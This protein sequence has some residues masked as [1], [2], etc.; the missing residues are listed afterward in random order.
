MSQETTG[1][2]PTLGH[3]RDALDSGT[4]APVRRMLQTLHPAEIG[5]MLESLPPTERS[6]VWDLVDP[7]DGGET[8]VHVTDEV[9]AS[10][11]ESMADE[12]LV[13]ATDGMEVDDLAD[14]VSD[15]PE[16]VT[17][18]ILLSM[19]LQNRQRLESILLYD[20]DTAGGLM[21]IDTITVRPAVTVD[22]VLRYLRQH[23]NIPDQTDT[24]FVVNR[25]GIYLG[26]LYITRL[27]THPETSTVE[28]L[29]EARVEGIDANTP[30]SEVAKRFED[31]DLVSAA[32]IDENGRLL[33]RI[34]IDD[35]VDV[36]REEAEHSLMSMAGLD[37]E[38]DMF[39]PVVIS[40]RRRAVWLGFNLAT[41]FVASWVVGFFEATIAQVVALAVLMP[42]VASM[43]GV[44][45]TQTLTL[46][47]RGL[48]LGQLE[49]S[50]TRWLTFKEVAVGAIN[51]LGWSIVIAGVT[52]LWFRD[53]RISAVIAAAMTINMITAALAGVVVPLVLQRLRIDPALAGSVV[54][55]TI[56]DVI[57]FAT[58]LGLGALFLV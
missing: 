56:T 29:M 48:A 14:L 54:L 22:V 45:G 40:A 52:W 10:L 12:A 55:T 36:I 25:Y 13:A 43:G 31:R 16:A 24:L 6:I 42:V 2:S 51:G 11:I 4:L 8:L 53:W 47:I 33:G 17:Q 7:D 18:R 49:K 46:V 19:D 9:R 58:F 28:E 3:L 50:N 1:Q 15:L 35:V 5:N 41:A 57:G 37:E 21:N 30:A 34:T 39:A 44:A 32:V 27:L 20:E 23:K 26:M 38:A